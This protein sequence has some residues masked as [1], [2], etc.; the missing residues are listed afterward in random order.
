MRPGSPHHRRR[1]R[2]PLR[3]RLSSASSLFKW[4]VA[5][6]SPFEGPWKLLTRDSWGHQPTYTCDDLRSDSCGV[7][8]YCTMRIDT[9]SHSNAHRSRPNKREPNQRSDIGE[10]CHRLVINILARASGSTA[11]SA[12]PRGSKS[13]I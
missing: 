3:P 1:H 10:R 8:V 5:F 11:G 9:T 12:L 4:V 6:W 13:N 7:V 2:R